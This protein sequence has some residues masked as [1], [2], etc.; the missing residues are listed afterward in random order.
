MSPFPPPTA[1]LSSQMMLCFS[2]VRRWEGGEESEEV[3]SEEVG[4]EGR[5]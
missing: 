4:S 5:E 2:P 3:R 1:S